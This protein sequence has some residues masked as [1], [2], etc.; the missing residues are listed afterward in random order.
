MALTPTGSASG[1]PYLRVETPKG[2]RNKYVW[3]DAR[4]AI[5]LDRFLFASVEYPAD[6][7][8]FPRTVADDGDPLAGFVC[9]SAPSFPGCFIPVKLVAVLRVAGDRGAD[10][11]LLCVPAKDP[12]WASVS[13]LEDVSQQLRTEIAHFVSISSQLEG[14]EVTVGWGP[15]EDALDM[16][17]RARRRAEQGRA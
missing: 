12:E 16:L 9:V 2:S 15:R 3:D 8:F 7:G 6:Y 5:R 17:A 11:R 10:D 14:R 1:A 4:G 13:D